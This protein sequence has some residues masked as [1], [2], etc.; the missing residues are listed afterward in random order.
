ML[1]HENLR[2]VRNDTIPAGEVDGE[3]VAL[4]L[5]N[6]N[7]FGMDQVGATIWSLAEKPVTLGEIVT[8]LTATHAVD[9]EQC[10]A[11][12]IPFINELLDEGLLLRS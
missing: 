6:G 12:I 3:L 10:L 2:I 1:L 11:D 8:S 7:C 4:D 9:R 5:E